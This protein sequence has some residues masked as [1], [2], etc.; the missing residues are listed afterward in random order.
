VAAFRD[1]V[2]EYGDQRSAAVGERLDRAAVVDEH[3]LRERV[4]EG[5]LAQ[6][7]LI[8]LRPLP[9]RK[10][11]PAT[12]QE[13]RQAVAGAHQ[14]P[15]RVVDATHEIAEALVRLAGHERERQLAGREQ[16]HQ[17]LGVTAV[18]LD[19]IPRRLGDR[20]RRDDPQVKTTIRRRACEPEPRRPGLIDSAHRSPELLQ[21]PGHDDPRRAPQALH[22]KLTAQR[23]EHCRDRLRLM[24]IQAHQSHTLR[25]GRHL[26]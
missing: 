12:Q 18:G 22:R 20:P 17:P 8:W 23:I 6:P 3:S 9:A 16:S 24:H 25:H 4:I 5:Q 1:R 11:Q 13:L 7:A 21:E 15:A 2:L 19:P 14:V 10:A 26:P